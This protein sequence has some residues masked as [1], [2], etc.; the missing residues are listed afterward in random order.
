MSTIL[1]D[2]AEESTYEHEEDSGIESFGKIEQLSESDFKEAE[3]TLNFDSEDEYDSTEVSPFSNKSSKQIKSRDLPSL[4]T[5]SEISD[6]PKQ[7]PSP[8]KV[9][10]IN[11]AELED[12]KNQVIKMQE[13]PKVTIEHQTV[14]FVNEPSVIA[15][16]ARNLALDPNSNAADLTLESL[17][18]QNEIQKVENSLEESK[19]EIISL[20][21]KDQCLKM[22]NATLTDNLTQL[23]DTF[24][25]LR[26][27]IITKRLSNANF[28]FK[29]SPRC[30]EM[31]QCISSLQ[32]QIKK[33]Q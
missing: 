25:P 19:S 26:Q 11:L 13:N 27:A 22:Q 31:L 23:R 28:D 32:D 3:V 12:M 33:L 29:N 17:D 7:S 30:V 2:V 1:P 6:K 9:I 14:K 16:R 21:Q 8:N 15:R 18:L 20:N 10:P 5:K 4:D 24:I